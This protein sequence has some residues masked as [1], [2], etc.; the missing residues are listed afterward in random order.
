MVSQSGFLLLFFI[1]FCSFVPEYC[2]Y[3][4]TIIGQLK[5]C[6]QELN[7]QNKTEKLSVDE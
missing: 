3:T 6:F 2:G 5:E 4:L 1:L 7:K